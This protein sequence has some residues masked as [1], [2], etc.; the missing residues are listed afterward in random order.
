MENVFDGEWR[1]CLRAH[2][3]HVVKQNDTRTRET[4]TIVLTHEAIN[5][6]ED[7]LRQ[8]YVE[9]TM[10]ADEFSEDQLR[11]IMEQVPAEEIAPPPPTL[12]DDRTFQPHPL[13]CQCPECMQINLMPH[14]EEGQPLS[15]EKI[16]ELEEETREKQRKQ[17]D[18]PKQLSLF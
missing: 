8:L 4:L 7:E 13:E 14:D 11:E 2:Y 17:D 16:E 1:E 15:Q 6:S 3:K 9:A 12:E 10:R 5:F 18:L